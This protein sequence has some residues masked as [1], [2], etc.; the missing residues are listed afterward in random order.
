MLLTPT[1][2]VFKMFRDHQEA[3]LLDS[4][5]TTEQIGTETDKVPNLTESVSV[6]AD[7]TI[8]ITL[9]NLSPTAAYPVDTVF[10][11][12]APACVTG[13]ILTGTMHAHNT[14]DA[15]ETV[16]TADFTEAKIEADAIRMTVPPCSVVSLKVTMK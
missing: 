8:L 12:G 11:E 6:A 16:K 13:K 4:S 9:A 5:L 14:F 15:P 1:Y 2:H 3:T 7:G 10:A